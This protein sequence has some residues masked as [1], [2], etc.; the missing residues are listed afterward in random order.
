MIGG[1]KSGVVFSNIVD[2]QM[3]IHSENGL[4]LI[5]MAFLLGRWLV[6][7]KNIYLTEVKS[8]KRH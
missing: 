8:F 5:S 3:Y 4:P 2:L 6:S 7:R 1:I